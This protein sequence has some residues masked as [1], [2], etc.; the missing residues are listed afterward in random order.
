MAPSKYTRKFFPLN[1]FQKEMETKL[2]KTFIGLLQKY[3][4]FIAQ[5]IHLVIGNAHKLKGA[6]LARSGNQGQV[7]NSSNA[8]RINYCQMK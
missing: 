8:M 2:K 1:V 5:D 7:P 3:V 6:P 4:N